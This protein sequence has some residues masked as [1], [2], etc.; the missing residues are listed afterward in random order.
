MSGAT[1]ERVL[2]RLGWRR[3]DPADRLPLRLEG[4]SLLARDIG[5]LRLRHCAGT[6]EAEPA[7][8]QSALLL[9]Q[10]EGTAV[11]H[12][13]GR[14]IELHPSCVL[15][16]PPGHQLQLVSEEPT[17]RIEVRQWRDSW[18]AGLPDDAIEAP[19]V[20]LSLLLITVSAML[21]SSAPIN[22]RVFTFLV[23]AVES[24]AN[25]LI[26]ELGGIPERGYPAEDCEGI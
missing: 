23:R 20:Y 7:L 18:G 26:S 8:T 21:T 19:E 25:A 1:A 9:V 5:L 11:L 4:E 14:P 15:F 16:L 13:N 17:M 24:A 2:A 12:V 3:V 6:Y 22:D 10:L